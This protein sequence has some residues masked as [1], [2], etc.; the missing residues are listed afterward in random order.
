[1]KCHKPPKMI[2]MIPMIPMMPSIGK[3]SAAWR[4]SRS[5][6]NVGTDV[7]LM[8]GGLLPALVHGF[9]ALRL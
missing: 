7:I 2:P 3:N 4:N 8:G 5:G 1:M 9:Q 6:N